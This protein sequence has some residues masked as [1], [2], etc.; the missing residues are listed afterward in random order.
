MSTLYQ[1][2]PQSCGRSG[3]VWLGK[4]KKNGKPRGRRSRLEKNDMTSGAS[5]VSCGWTTIGSSV[6]GER[7]H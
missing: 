5:V 1:A 7:H 6:R 4:L 2:G 3:Y